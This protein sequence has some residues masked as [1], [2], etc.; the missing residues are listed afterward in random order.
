MGEDERACTRI[1]QLFED[2]PYS[3]Q[4]DE[5]AALADEMGCGAAAGP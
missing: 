5:A 4:H 1:E 3:N 2:F